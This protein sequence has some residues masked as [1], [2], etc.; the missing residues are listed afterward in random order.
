[1]LRSITLGVALCVLAAACALFEPPI[2][3]GTRGIEVEVRNQTQQPLALGV[4][5]KNGVAPG[6]AQPTLMGPGTA[7]VTFYVPTEGFYRIVAD[8]D[9]QYSV[10]KGDVWRFFE[11]GCKAYI[12]VTFEGFSHGCD[13]TP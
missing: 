13:Q 2:P 5:T 6:G 11:P 3:A 10:G 4:T 8:R 7:V 1:V 12:L 9:R